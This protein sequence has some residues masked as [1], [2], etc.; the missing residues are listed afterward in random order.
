MSDEDDN[1]AVGELI[2]K[3]TDGQLTE[4]IAG[5][6][7]DVWKARRAINHAKLLEYDAT[8][9]LLFLMAETPQKLRVSRMAFNHCLQ[10]SSLSDAEYMHYKQARKLLMR[11]LNITPTGDLFGG[12]DDEE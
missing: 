9:K 12:L 2:G 6:L 7:E 3:F 8:N 10:I 11:A 5:R 4:L 1:K